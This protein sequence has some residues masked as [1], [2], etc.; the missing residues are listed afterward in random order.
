[1]LDGLPEEWIIERDPSGRV[2]AVKASVVAGFIYHD[3]FYTREQAAQVA[4]GEPH[5]KNI[6]QEEET[7]SLPAGGERT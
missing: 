4:G 5:G 6:R 2:V 1:V 3:R 7:L